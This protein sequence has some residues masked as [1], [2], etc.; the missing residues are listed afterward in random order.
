MRKEGLCQNDKKWPDDNFITHK[1]E[2]AFG[3]SDQQLAEEFDRAAEAYAQ[4]PDPG[5]KPP[6]GEFQKIMERVEREKKA[7]RKVIRLKRVL[8]PMLVAALLGGAILGSGIGVNGLEG[9]DYRPKEREAGDVIF[10]NMDNIDEASELEQAYKEIEEK[11]G[12]SAIELSYIPDEMVFKEAFFNQLR[13]KLE[14]VYKGNRFYFHQTLW[15]LNESANYKSDR[16]LYKEVYNRYLNSYISIYKN[17]LDGESPEFSA[18]F[19]DGDAYYYIFGIIDED[20]FIKIV[21]HIKYYE[22]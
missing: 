7:E 6:E 22:N 20:E 21:E 14:F 12:I 17:E 4:N 9:T 10:S 15:N 8:R 1:L 3:Y 11:L 19:I 16:E 13:S 5:L 2:E 18:Q